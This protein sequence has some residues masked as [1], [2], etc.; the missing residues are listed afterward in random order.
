MTESKLLARQKLRRALL[1]EGAADEVD[2]GMVDFYVTRQHPSA[3]LAEIQNETLAVIRSLVSD[4]LF[5]LGAMTGEGRRWEPWD[6]PLEESMRK[7][8]EVYLNHYDDPSAW[9]WYAWMKLTDE[10]RK[11]AQALQE[12]AADMR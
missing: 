9:I 2:L 7:I 6:E 4:G 11:A 12:G 10:G 8:A 5:V 1:I 3:S